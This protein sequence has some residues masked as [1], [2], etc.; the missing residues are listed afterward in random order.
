MT[1]EMELFAQ[2]LLAAAPGGSGCTAASSSGV[3]FEMAALFPPVPLIP[4]FFGF[5][6][7]IHGVLQTLT[8][9]ALTS[10]FFW[11]REEEEKKNNQQHPLLI[12]ALIV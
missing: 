9:I 6:E 12:L 4:F 2:A 10:P 3:Y 11:G 8:S 5:G 7:L 1:L